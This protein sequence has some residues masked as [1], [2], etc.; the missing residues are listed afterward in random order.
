M[1]CMN[2]ATTFLLDIA[3]DVADAAGHRSTEHKA[4][5]FER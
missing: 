2:I 4:Q 5:N 1:G 3:Q